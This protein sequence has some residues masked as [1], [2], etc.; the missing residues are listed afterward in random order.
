MAGYTCPRCSGSGKVTVTIINWST[1][2]T[3]DKK[4]TCDRCNG[5]GEVKS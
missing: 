2:K 3:E 4:E 1:Q 5:S